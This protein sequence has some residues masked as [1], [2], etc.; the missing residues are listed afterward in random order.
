MKKK[1]LL[2]GG[3]FDPPHKSHIRTAL[4]AINHKNFGGD[5]ELWFLP[6]YS[7]A[8]GQK[9]LTDPK[10]RV[11]MLNNVLDYVGH[12]N[13]EICTIEIEMANSAGTYAIVMELRRRHP[14]REFYYVIGSDQAGRIREWRNSRDLL[15]TIPFVIVKRPLSFGSIEWCFS[16]PHTWIENSIKLFDMPNGQTFQSTEIRERFRHKW[17]LY[18]DGVPSREEGLLYDVNQYV[19]KNELYKE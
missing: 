12:N 15:K 11:A 8:F 13:F 14:D 17:K 19:I 6:C 18:H 3:A 10:H 4:T 9:K 16:K 5:T 7:D 2:F 1:T